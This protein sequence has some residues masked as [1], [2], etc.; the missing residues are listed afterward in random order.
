[1][2]FF[3]SGL[4]L[5][6]IFTLLAFFAAN[7]MKTDTPA[8]VPSPQTPKPNTPLQIKGSIP[9]WDQDNAF[10]SVEK[11]AASLDYINLFWYYLGA[12]GD[13]KKYQYAKED[14]NLISF[15]HENNIKVFAVLTN[16]PEKEDSSWDSKRVEKILNN[17]NLREKHI[18]DILGKLESVNFDGITIDYESVK[19]SQRNQ[20]SIFIEELASALNSKGQLVA[21]ALHPK[22]TPKD[23]K[24]GIG[25]FQDLQALAES[26]D[27]LNIMAYGEHYDESEPGPIAS[28]PWLEEIIG[29]AKSLKISP[30]KIYLGVPLYGYD[31]NKD[32]DEGAAGLTYVDVLNL[33]KKQSVKES[34][35]KKS[36]S[37]YFTYEED[38]DNHEVW[39]ENA[40]SVSEK[41]KLAKDAGLAGITFWRFGGEDPSIWNKIQEFK[42]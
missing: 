8:I 4:T 35:D 7:Y 39:F 3:Y 1:M 34:W 24:N 30:E 11:N 27:Q 31:W 15:A 23:E 16:L 2:K 40:R 32:N 33:A 20:F 13:I 10:R 5:V 17:T 25:A 38:G 18:N 9:Y 26:A 21:V 42:K 41:I 19:P 28:M 22:K 36:K 37:P 29:Y 6:I 12:D 14:K